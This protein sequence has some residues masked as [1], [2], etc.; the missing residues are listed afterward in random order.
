MP[1]TRTVSTLGTSRAARASRGSRL[2]AVAVALAGLGLGACGAAKPVQP[3]GKPPSPT[4]IT[5]QNPGGDAADPEQAALE[6]LANQPFGARTDEFRTLRVPVPDWPHWDRVTVFGHPTR[7]NVR[8]GDERY[9]LG[10]VLYRPIDGASTPERCLQ[11]FN[12]DADLVAKAYGVRIQRG[13]VE[14]APYRFQGEERELVMQVQDGSIDSVL[15]RDDYV[16]AVVSYP[17]WPGTCLVYGFAVMS[18]NHP[19]LAER[20]RDRF[21]DD[22]ADRLRWER[23]VRKAPAFDTK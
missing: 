20:V 9:A 5:T 7:L 14:R 16:G 23:K 15:A 2:G 22:G 8:Y 13:A 12:A 19:E 11:K 17:S 4:S 10:T 6:R 1:R 21:L 18:T 3:P